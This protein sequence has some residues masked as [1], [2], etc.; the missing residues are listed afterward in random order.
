MYKFVLFIFTFLLAIATLAQVD[1]TERLQVFN[2]KTQQD[3]IRVRAVEDVAWEY[4]Y[5]DLD[6]ALKYAL[7]TEEFARKIKDKK[8][9]A[10]AYSTVGA[11]YGE[12][13]KIPMSLKYYLSAL[14]YWESIGND[15]EIAGTKNNIGS[16]YTILTQYDKAE[17]H[18]HEA[19]EI[20]LA[21]GFESRLAEVY[22]NYAGV[23]RERGDRAEAIVYYL[24]AL[25]IAK[26]IEHDFM[27][28]MLESNLAGTYDLLH[29][30]SLAFVWYERALISTA[31]VNDLHGMASLYNNIGIF[32]NR[33]KDYKSGLKNCRVSLAL[34]KEVGVH[35]TEYYSCWCLQ[36]AFVGLHQFDSA[37]YYQTLSENL[38]DTLL[39]E[40]N[41]EEYTRMEMQFDFEKVQLE[42]SLANVSKMQIIDLEHEADLQREQKFKFALYGGLLIALLIGA[43]IF[44][45]LKVTNRQKAVI[46]NQKQKVDEAYEQLEEKN[47]EIMDSI[48][49]AR[50]IQSAILPPAKLVKAYLQNSFIL[51]KPKDIVAGDFYWMQTQEISPTSSRILFAV[52]DCTGHGV[53]GA[54]VSVVCNNALNRAVREYELSDPGEILDKTREI[55]I[56]EFEKSD[57]DVKDGMDIALCSLE[58]NQLKFSGA[59]NPFWLIRKGAIIE[60]NANKQPIGKFETNV[61]FATHTVQLESGDSCYLFSDGYSDQFGGDKGKKFKSSNF[62]KLLLSIQELSMDDQ[63]IK[64]NE[65]FETWRGTLEQLDDG[66]VIGVR[67]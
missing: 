11:I 43:F 27:I 48:T 49:Y 1:I 64:I 22:I 5:T 37:Y 42:D 20:C 12:M 21:N 35:S 47:K 3:T 28:A 67:F 16:N 34:S 61:H 45:R 65:A 24:K 52:A 30:D 44:Y 56:S 57:E 6:S 15:Y 7:I 2:N 32:H 36:E 25:E 66:C 9:S 55:V 19:I 39:N 40:K 23:F 4:L 41:I 46:Q 29:Q 17:N 14:A 54:L 38:E 13:G 10:Y 31:A 58:G 26:K 62:K 53:P 59:H 63:K 60:V 33:E 51:Y 8:W 18:L 50:R